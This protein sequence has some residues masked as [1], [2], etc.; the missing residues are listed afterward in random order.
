MRLKLRGT[1]VNKVQDV[2]II[3]LLELG[4]SREKPQV[5]TLE[6]KRLQE[7]AMLNC[8]H[9]SLMSKGALK[10]GLG[11]V[12][13]HEVVNYPPALSKKKAVCVAHQRQEKNC[14]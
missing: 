8:R 11:L 10:M 14:L 5:F 6:M 13:I 3:S 12:D 2:C 1:G 9:F 4:N 7:G